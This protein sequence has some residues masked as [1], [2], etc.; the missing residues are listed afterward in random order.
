M[1]KQKVGRTCLFIELT[2]TVIPADAA[3]GLLKLA[4]ARMEEYSAIEKCAAVPPIRIDSGTPC[5]PTPSSMNGACILPP[6]SPHASVL[7]GSYPPCQNHW[8]SPANLKRQ[9]VQDLHEMVKHEHPN[10]AQT[11]S[12][13]FYGSNQS[14]PSHVGSKNP[15][16]NI[17]LPNQRL[18]NYYLSPLA[19]GGTGIQ[20][21]QAPYTMQAALSSDLS[22]THNIPKSRLLPHFDSRLTGKK[23]KVKTEVRVHRLPPL[24][25]GSNLDIDD[26][27]SPLIPPINSLSPYIGSGISEIP[28]FPSILSPINSAHLSRKRALSTSPLSDMF[29]VY[30]LRSSPNSLM[31]TLC[32]N[33]SSPMTPNGS[34]P[35]SNNGTVGHLI[36]QSNTPLQAMQYRVQ[37]RKTSIEHNQNDDGTTNTTITNQITFSNPEARAN[38]T[39]QKSFDGEPMEMD[40]FNGH[41]TL[42]NNL[43][44]PHENEDPVEPHLCLWEGCGLNFDD[45][46]DL[47]QHIENTHIEKGRAN[48]YVCFWQHCIRGR[49]SFNARYKLLI[50]MRIHSGEKP[51]KCT[52]SYMWSTANYLNL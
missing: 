22:P 18:P 38:L 33:G 23:G 9:E 13:M 5:P 4:F 34:V 11:S 19:T 26:A 15:P 29:D 21:L 8:N 40:T 46:D 32:N 45:L 52:V 41:K 6:I 16:N 1:G 51:N 25:G 30:A 39:L 50:H 37:Q 28:S 2:R 14:Q 12:C 27:L 24:P 43:Q 47:V 31:T 20:Q 17:H 44:Y 49:K 42:T 48:E 7:S 3:V 36:G 35:I 10:F